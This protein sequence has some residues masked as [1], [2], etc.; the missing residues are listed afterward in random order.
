MEE[1]FVNIDGTDGFYQVSNLGNVKSVRRNI[2]LKPGVHKY[3]HSEV[4]LGSYGH[5]YIHRLVA[6]IFIPNP[7][8]KPYIDHIDGNPRNNIYT[9]L[10][11]VTQKENC[12]NPISIERYKISNRNKSSKSYSIERRDSK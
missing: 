12:N 8:N 2:I 9:N 6:Q 7:E 5:F 1:I 4:K 3:G 11:W 10:R